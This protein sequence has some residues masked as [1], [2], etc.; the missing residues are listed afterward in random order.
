M[1]DKIERTYLDAA[2]VG[3]LAT[4]DEDGRPNVVP[5]CFAV[6]DTG[7]GGTDIVSPIDEKPKSR[8]PGGLRRSRDIQEN[9]FV[10]LVVDE[11]TEAWTDLGWVQVR[12]QAKHLYPGNKLHGIAIKALRDKYDQYRSHALEKN[13]VIQITPGSVISW[14]SIDND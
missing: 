9:P 5:I 1:F 10:S 8:S 13:P 14:G 2:R 3:R 4:A 6:V 11:Y 7:A 12:G